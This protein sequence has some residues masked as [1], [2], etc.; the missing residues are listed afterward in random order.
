MVCMYKIIWLDG[1]SG[2]GKTTV[3]NFL[4]NELMENEIT[5][6]NVDSDYYY[7]E[8]YLLNP[9]IDQSKVKSP[10]ADEC[11]LKYFKGQLVLFCEKN[12]ILV[13]QM[14][15]T[16]DKCRK[17]LLESLGE[18]VGIKHIILNASKQT[19][20]DRLKERATKGLA[21]RQ[22]LERLDW[23]IAYLNKYYKEDTWINTEERSAE[24]VA[25]E[26]FSMIE[27]SRLQK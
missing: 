19:I 26:I 27:K 17:I 9:K 10:W 22:A 5:V 12:D 7:Q 24:N 23:N 8:K 25:D 11:F 15:L 14:A 2:V 6:D 1:A 20:K 4:T 18:K 16:D 21:Q 3:A 13:V